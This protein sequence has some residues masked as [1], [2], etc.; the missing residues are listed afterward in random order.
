[1]ELCP[2][3]RPP[4]Q[5]NCDG[6]TTCTASASGADQAGAAAEQQEP[7][8]HAESAE[9]VRSDAGAAGSSAAGGPP[10]PAREPEQ[11]VGQQPPRMAV[12]VM[13]YCGSA[14]A[15]RVSKTAANPDRE[16]YCCRK[17][18]GQ[19][20]CKYFQWADALAAAAAG[21][22]LG[23]MYAGGCCL[24]YAEICGLA[25]A[26]DH[27]HHAAGIEAIVPLSCDILQQQQSDSA[28]RG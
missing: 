12:N 27:L 7:Q 22:C 20:K 9:A 5:T 2:P 21:G 1:M 6:L 18:E 13:C 19:G 25:P 3:C 10:A 28:A 14:A 11:A 17:L 26:S 8:Q 24:V 4:N 23:L 16:F 15:Q